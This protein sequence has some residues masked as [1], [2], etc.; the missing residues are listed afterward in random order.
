[1]SDQTQPQKLDLA[2]RIAEALSRTDEP[3]SPVCDLEFLDGVTSLGKLP[4]HLRHL[5][6]LAE[7]S[8]DEAEAARAKTDL[9]GTQ[10]FEFTVDAGSVEVATEKLEALELAAFMAEEEADV[11]E[12]L[13]FA[14]LET[15]I[16]TQKIYDYVFILHDWSVIGLNED[17]MVDVDMTKWTHSD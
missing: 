7:D 1:M 15:H 3:R 10:L 6:I 12:T 16:P 8:K 11:A 2:Q 13:L 4:F 14:S 17:D 5:A 9:Y